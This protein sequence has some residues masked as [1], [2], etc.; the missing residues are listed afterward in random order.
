MR[1]DPRTYLWDAIEAADQAQSFA[2]GQ[3][4]DDYLANPMLRSA[5]ERL[6][7]LRRAMRILL[8]SA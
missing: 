3:T 1:R 8:E 5:V 7:E 6:P 2:R 4:L